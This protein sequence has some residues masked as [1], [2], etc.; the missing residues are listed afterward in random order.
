MQ[1]RIV[2]IVNTH[3]NGVFKDQIPVYYKQGYGECLPGDWFDIIE[4]CP[5]I[6]LE[7]GVDNAIILQRSEIKK[8]EVKSINLSKSYFSIKFLI[9]FFP[10]NI[11][12]F[13]F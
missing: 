3:M 1:T 8:E 7:K 6:T 9:Q 4:E 13:L 5:E 10:G 11:Y 12:V 2:A